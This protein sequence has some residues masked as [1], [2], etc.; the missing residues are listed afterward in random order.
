MGITCHWI[1]NA[2]NIQKLLL[3]YRCFNDPHTAQNIS[4]LMF[5]IL[6]KYCL[7]S[8]IFSISFDNASAKTCSIDE[9]IRMCQPSIGGKF[10]HIRCTCHIFNL[11][12]QDGLK[13]LELYIKPLRSTIHYLWTHPQ[14]MKQ[15]GKFC[16]LNGMRAKRFA[17]DV[18]TRW[19]STYNFLL[20]TFEYKDLLCGFFGQVQS[21]NIYLYA[22]Q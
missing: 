8:K 7:T 1:D 18:P 12:V 11:C 17:R 20:S 5:I 10:F 6:E 13:S 21:S 22:N 9:L 3:A 15:W 14:V 16:K 2:W 4:H 19:N